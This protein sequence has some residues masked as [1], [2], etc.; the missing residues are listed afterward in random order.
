MKG[1]SLT[2]AAGVF[3]PKTT[4]SRWPPYRTGVASER[5]LEILREVATIAMNT[6]MRWRPFRWMLSG[7]SPQLGT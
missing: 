6:S 3:T 2:S 7:R 5:A 4:M 1:L